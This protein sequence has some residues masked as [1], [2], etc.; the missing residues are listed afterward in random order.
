MTD[1]ASPF[2]ALD[3]IK[4]PITQVMILEELHRW[5]SQ[6][7]ERRSLEVLADSIGLRLGVDDEGGTSWGTRFGPWAT[8]G[9]GETAIEVP[10]RT[11]I[12]ADLIEVWERRARAARHPVLR[13]RYADLVWDL[14]PLVR[15]TR[16]SVE[17][18]RMVIDAVIGGLREGV[19]GWEVEAYRSADRALDLAK[20]INDPARAETVERA[21]LAY[22]RTHAK[23]RLAGTWGKSFELVL[24]G[25]CR[26][27]RSVVNHRPLPPGLRHRWIC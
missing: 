4:G 27:P 9:Q 11:E 13:A 20:S 2:D 24:S 17:F 1:A 14:S 7:P 18:P 23:D 6:P 21:L 16:P 5:D 15:K 26:F 12:T 25:E 19:L 10:A 8:F 22:E 3:A